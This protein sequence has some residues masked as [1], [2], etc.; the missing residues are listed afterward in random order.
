MPGY[1]SLVATQLGFR[2]ILADQVGM[3][4]G[5]GLQALRATYD[6]LVVDAVRGAKS[7]YLTIAGDATS[8]I[9]DDKDRKTGLLFSEGAAV[10]LVTNDPDLGEDGYQ[11]TKI[12][13]KSLLGEGI[14]M[15][16]VMNPLHPDV[17]SNHLYATKPGFWMDGKGVYEFGSDVMPHFLELI[18]K[19]K[20]GSDWMLFPHQPN[21]R[22]LEEMARRSGVP[23]EQIY[24]EGIQTIGNTSPP[25]VFLGLQ[26][27]LQ[28]N[29]FDVSNTVVLG[30]FGAELTVGA[31][32]LK[33]VGDPK[34]I[35]D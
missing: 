6:R 4:C 24:M 20:F 31:A 12:N 16:T 32:M 3:G 25:A 29:L 23:K 33:P 30:A 26:D 35:V 27:G 10:L 22:M 34:A 2:N 18:E 14:N 15:M 5:G 8:L 28:R 19:S 9:L 1:A 13:T 11:I 17:L 7:S 21:L